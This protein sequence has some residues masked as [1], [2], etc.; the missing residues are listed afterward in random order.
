MGFRTSYGSY[1]S[2]VSMEK[3]VVKMRQILE[4]YGEISL[5]GFRKNLKIMWRKCHENVLKLKTEKKM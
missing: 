4:F 3:N 2:M 5:Y 1:G